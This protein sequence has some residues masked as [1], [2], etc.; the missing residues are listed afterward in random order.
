MFDKCP[1]Y[2]SVKKW[3]ANFQQE[4]FRAK[5][6]AQSE[7]LSA[8]STSEIVNHVPDL[9]LANQ[10]ISIK[11]SVKT[12]NISRKNV[13]FTI[14]DQL[15]MQNLSAKQVSKSLNAN[16]KKYWVNNSKLFIQHFQCSSDEAWLHHN[17]MK[18]NNTP[19]NGSTWVLHSLRKSKP[20][21]QQ[22]T[23]W[24]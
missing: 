24:L 13:W 5:D 20:T 22:Q 15:D 4:D 6:E 3:Y 8:V 21:N 10:Q 18:T 14:H 9:T 16:Q 12:L 1:S 19:Y 2:S 7:R 23:S 11:K 17:D